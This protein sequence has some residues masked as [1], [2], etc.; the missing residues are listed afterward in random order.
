MAIAPQ[1]KEVN[2]DVTGM[3]TLSGHWE[4]IMQYRV[5][6]KIILKDFELKS[7]IQR[8]NFLFRM[9]FGIR[10]T[11][12]VPLATVKYEKNSEICRKKREKRVCGCIIASKFLSFLRRIIKWSWLSPSPALG[13]VSNKQK[14]LDFSFMSSNTVVH[15]P[16]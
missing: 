3:N 11:S 12:L 7:D 10:I 6:Q 1:R 4:T 13:D 8:P 14:I 16:Q 15:S 2:K 9:C 5:D